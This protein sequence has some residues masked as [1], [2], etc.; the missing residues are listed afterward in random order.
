[1]TL[2]EQM[3]P[4]HISDVAGQDSVKKFILKSLDAPRSIILQGQAGCGKTTLASLYRQACSQLPSYFVSGP[5]TDTDEIRMIVQRAY[6]AGPI[7]LVLDE[8]QYLTKKQQQLLLAPIES[9][10][11][12]LVATTT[13]HVSAVLHAG[14]RSR[15]SVFIL[16]PPDTIS[17]LRILLTAVVKVQ[18]KVDR[19][20]LERIAE[21]C[22]G[23][24]RHALISLEHLLIIYD[25][26]ITEELYAEAMLTKVSNISVEEY[27]SAL[28]KSIRGSDANASCLYALALLEMG[29]LETL[30]RRLRVIV[31][32]N[33]GLANP[34]GPVIVNECVANALTIGMPEARYPILHA[35]LWLALQP[36]SN[37]IAEI[38]EKFTEEVSDREIVPPDN[39]R[40]AHSRS[41][42]YPHS[43]PNH[44][45]EQNYLPEDM[46]KL[47]LYSAQPNKTERAYEEYWRK[48][49]NE[50]QNN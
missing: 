38:I 42:V 17:V 4:N 41:Y 46:A 3:R 14:I 32:E 31:S 1:M 20:I 36:K 7:L 47:T 34:I 39:I 26:E 12:V 23:D 45:F 24:V 15:C 27:K 11:L 19:K 2:A 50:Q 8:I 48:I 29:E 33:V 28:Q 25:D 44:W 6:S 49:K 5:A 16:K 13:E 22:G 43:F 21:E 10:K 37:S 30:C 35:V 9:N 40:Y 18:R